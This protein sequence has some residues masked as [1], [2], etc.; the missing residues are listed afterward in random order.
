LRLPWEGDD[1]TDMLSRIVPPVS[2]QPMPQGL[3][4]ETIIVAEP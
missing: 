4:P 2:C 3:L 1:V